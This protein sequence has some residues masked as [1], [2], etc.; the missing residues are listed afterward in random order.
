MSNYRA[1]G[2]LEIRMVHSGINTRENTM[3]NIGLTE[4]EVNEIKQET[5]QQRKE[6]TGLSSLEISDQ[7]A[8][9]VQKSQHRVTLDSMK[10]KITDEEF[11]HPRTMPHMT[12]CVL[13]TDNGF[14]L[15]GKSTPADPENFDQ[16]LGEKFAFEDALRQMWP[17]EAYLLREILSK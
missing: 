10:A 7:A 4:A 15:V 16:E 3:S 12:I 11:L 2:G 14:A 5:D 6:R 8:A 17:L 9:A 1:D 13:T